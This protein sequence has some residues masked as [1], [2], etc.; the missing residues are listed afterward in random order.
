M[1]IPHFK[2]RNDAEAYL[3][4]ERK[5]ELVFD[6][7]NYHEEKKIKLAVVEFTDYALCGG[8]N[9]SLLDGVIESDQFPLGER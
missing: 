6:C 9:Y 4:W 2:G 5:V 1:R 3:E 8:I 7:H